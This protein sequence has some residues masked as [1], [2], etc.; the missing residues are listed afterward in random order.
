MPFDV[1]GQV[2]TPKL[3][4]GIDNYSVQLQQRYIERTVVNQRWVGGRDVDSNGIT[5][6]N[7]TNLQLGY[8]GEMQN[9]GTWRLAFNVTN[10]LD[11][12]PPRIASYGTHGGAQ[13]VNANYDIY[14]RRYQV[15]LNMDF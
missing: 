6:G 13:N 2:G 3:T 12:N 5:S 11:R 15:S 14:G 9:G 4:Y 1:S 10:L 8:N 7:T